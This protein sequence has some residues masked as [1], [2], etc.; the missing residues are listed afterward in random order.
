MQTALH[1]VIPKCPPICRCISYSLWQGI[2]DE[3]PDG[4]PA[5]MTVPDVARQ[6][7]EIAGIIALKKKDLM[8]GKHDTSLKRRLERT[9]K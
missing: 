7:A 1:R 9:R 8:D 4:V 5:T 3:F 2:T 6:L